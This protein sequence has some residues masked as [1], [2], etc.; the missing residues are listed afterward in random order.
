MSGTSRAWNTL[1]RLD[2]E[3]EDGVLVGNRFVHV[4]SERDAS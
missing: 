2:T 3:I 1:R 4:R